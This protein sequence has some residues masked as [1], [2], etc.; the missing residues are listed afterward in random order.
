MKLIGMIVRREFSQLV[1]THKDRLLRFGSDM[2]MRICEMNDIRVTLVNEDDTAPSRETE[3]VKDVIELMTV[4]S[5]RLYGSRSKRN[6][7]LLKAA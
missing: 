1:L 7:A 3:L 6:K 4:F 2:L 5:A